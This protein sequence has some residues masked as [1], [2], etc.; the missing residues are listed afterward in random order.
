MMGFVEENVY[1]LCA[2]FL[3]RV[4]QTRTVIP[5]KAGI[6]FSP[7]LFITHPYESAV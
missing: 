5:A 2:P 4:T 3:G 7:R 1:M 6:Q